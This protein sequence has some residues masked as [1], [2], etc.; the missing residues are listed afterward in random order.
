MGRPG[1]GRALGRTVVVEPVLRRLRIRIF[2]SRGGSQSLS[3]HLVAERR[4]AVLSGLACPPR[5]RMDAGA[6]ARHR[7]GG[8]GDGG[9]GLRS[10]CRDDRA[11]A[12]ACLLSDAV[13]AVAVGAGSRRPSVVRPGPAFP[14]RGSRCTCRRLPVARRGG[15]VAGAGSRFVSGRV[16]LAADAGCRAAAVERAR[17]VAGC[18]AGHEAAAILG[19]RVVQ[20]VSVA[21]ADTGTGLRPVWPHC[22]DRYGGSGTLAASGLAQLEVGRAARPLH[23]P[24]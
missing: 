3:A 10:D 4:G 2:R 8:V 7:R 24:G 13:P 23:G 9:A 12:V 16:G 17:P 1:G 18:L 14:A 15:G 6:T 5:R 19:P 20:L 21:L 22:A 11:A